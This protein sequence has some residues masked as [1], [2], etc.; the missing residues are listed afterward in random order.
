[1]SFFQPI[2]QTIQPSNFFNNQQPRLHDLPIQLSGNQDELL[3]S[4]DNNRERRGT[5]QTKRMK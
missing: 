4:A 5:K 2:N 3:M 1:M